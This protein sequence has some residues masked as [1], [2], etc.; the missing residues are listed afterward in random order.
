MKLADLLTSDQILLDMLSRGHW[1]AIVELIDHL[2]SVGRLGGEGER[3]EVL[4]ALRTR[5]GL[6]ST[7]IGSGVAI[8]HVMSDRINEVTAVFGRS[9]AGI[10]FEAVDHAPVHFV[11][12][13]LVPRKNHAL[14]LRTLGAIAKTFARREVRSHLAAAKTREEIIDV[15]SGKSVI[16]AGETESRLST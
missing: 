3:A 6:V 2:W 5:E 7:G 12:L 9:L 11:V 14:H 13:F 1:E 10:D 8:P 15:L 16:S 4:E